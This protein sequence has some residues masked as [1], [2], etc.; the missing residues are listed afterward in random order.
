MRLSLLKADKCFI[1]NKRG[2]ENIQ[3]LFG[4][5]RMNKKTMLGIF[6]I[7]IATGALLFFIRRGKWD[8]YYKKTL[9]RA[10]ATV[11]VEA[12]SLFEYPGNALDLGCGV[13]NETAYLLKRGWS[14]WV[15]DSQ[16]GAF[17]WLLSRNDITQE[18][19]L[20]PI[21]AGFESIDWQSLPVMD[22]VLAAKALPFCLPEKFAM[23]WQNLINKIKPGGRFAGEF[24]GTRYRGYAQQEA[25]KMTFLTKEQVV[26]LFKDFTIEEIREIEDTE[27]SASAT[28]SA[29]RVHIFEVIAQK[30]HST[31]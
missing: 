17:K 13:G 25:Q 8:N 4:V 14:V 1:V 28:G 2:K 22:F 15:V 29:V 12:E 9:Y 27:D 10:P 24:F 31:R 16:A 6:V 23:V 21:V 3:I 11:I 7:I 19:L 18:A 30:N 26:D 20:H 5:H